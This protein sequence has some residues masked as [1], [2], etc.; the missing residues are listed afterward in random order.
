M[1]NCLHFVQICGALIYVALPSDKLP[2]PDAGG[3][4]FKS[5]IFFHEDIFGNLGTNLVFIIPF[6]I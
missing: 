6:G 4:K 5:R 1:Q 2:V 3:P